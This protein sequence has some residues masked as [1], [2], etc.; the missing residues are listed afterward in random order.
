MP[1][2]GEGTPDAGGGNLELVGAGVRAG[3]VVQDVG[4]GLGD[5]GDDVEADAAGLLLRQVHHNV[6][7][8]VGAGDVD[9]NVL[10]VQAVCQDRGL[11]EGV[12]APASWFW[13]GAASA[14]PVPVR[15]VEVV[16]SA[17]VMMPAASR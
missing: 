14:F 17:L 11:Q 15:S 6:D 13:A 8:P 1:L 5:L 4:E 9:G 12:Q 16:A 7:H 10:E 3:I 2:L